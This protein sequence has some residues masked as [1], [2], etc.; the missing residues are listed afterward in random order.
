MFD[1]YIKSGLTILV[2]NVIII[3]CLAGYDKEAI[4][5]ENGVLI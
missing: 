2:V 1:G 4:E 3:F 5:E